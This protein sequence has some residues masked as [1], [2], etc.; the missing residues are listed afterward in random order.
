MEKIAKSYSDIGIA[1]TTLVTPKGFLI[2]RSF[3]RN[4]IT[5]E[6]RSSVRETV[7]IP[8]GFS[9]YHLWSKE[10]NLPHDQIFC[11]KARFTVPPESVKTLLLGRRFRKILKELRI[12]QYELIDEGY[13]WLGYRIIRPGHND[14]Y[15]V[16]CKNWGASAGV[17]SFWVPLF[18]FGKKYTLRFVPESHSR[19]Y[20]SYLLENSKFTKGELR[21]DPSENVD[22]TSEFVRPCSALIFHPALLHSEDVE[23][24]NKTRIN[25]EFRI[26]SL[27]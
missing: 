15:P 24:G 25:L 22:T 2:L 18:G 9:R 7:R 20:K 16:S 17:I 26:R 8:R 21:L 14:G 3:A 13:G 5:R 4:W 23:R 10:H 12:D 6:I 1:N 19:S 11:A 27:N